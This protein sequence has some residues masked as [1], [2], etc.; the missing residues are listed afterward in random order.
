LRP[1]EIFWRKVVCTIVFN[2]KWNKIIYNS[3]KSYKGGLY[4]VFKDGDILF[5]K[6][7]NDIVEEI[8][9]TQ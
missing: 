4:M 3:N 5:A 9:K 7:L 8:I 6:D 2:F 1:I